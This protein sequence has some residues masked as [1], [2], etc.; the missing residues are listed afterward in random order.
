[1]VPG[2][3]ENFALEL[4]DAVSTAG[5]ISTGKLHPS[6]YAGAAKGQP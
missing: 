4:C 2:H 1:M 6:C 5:G 3:A